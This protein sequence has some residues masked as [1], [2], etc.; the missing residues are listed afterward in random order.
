MGRSMADALRAAGRAP[1][2]PA[3]LAGWQQPHR[4]LGGRRSELGGRVLCSCGATC[5]AGR[6]SCGRCA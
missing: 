6:R 3:E 2:R 5:P 4:A 1:E